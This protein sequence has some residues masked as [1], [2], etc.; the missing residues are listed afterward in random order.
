MEISLF[1]PRFHADPKPSPPPRP[2]ASLSSTDRKSY[3]TA[4]AHYSF[5]WQPRERRISGFSNRGQWIVPRMPTS[6][7]SLGC[8]VVLSLHPDAVHDSGESLSRHRISLI[9]DLRHLD[10]GNVSGHHSFPY[11]P[12]SLDHSVHL[13]RLA[14]DG[15]PGRAPSLSSLS[16]PT[17]FEQEEHNL[18]L[19][20]GFSLK[21]TASSLLAGQALICVRRF[22]PQSPSRKWESQRY[23][24]EISLQPGRI[25]SQAK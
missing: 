3:S 1:I 17:T 12:P 4:E 24:M 16:I 22:S 23:W 8:A 11:H 18:L 9:D 14:I 19:M 7:A 20:T 5:T 13:D 15:I 21:G 10:P 25:G 6:A 2:H